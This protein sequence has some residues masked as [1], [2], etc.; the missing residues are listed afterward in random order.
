MK[1]GLT[2]FI[3]CGMV[4]YKE[5][6]ICHISYPFT[7]CDFHNRSSHRF[8]KKYFENHHITVTKGLYNNTIEWEEVASPSIFAKI[9][10]ESHE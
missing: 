3:K 1:M 10:E 6:G 2:K 4:F 7:G 9:P 5:V 8:F